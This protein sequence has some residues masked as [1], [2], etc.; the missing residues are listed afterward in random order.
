MVDYLKNL[1]LCPL[2]LLLSLTISA[3]CK[4][5]HFLTPSDSVNVM[6]RNTVIGSGVGLYL[7]GSIWLYQSWYRNYPRTSFHLF[8][9]WNEWNNMDKLGHIYSGYGQTKYA[10]RALRWTGMKKD[11]SLLLG[12]ATGLV[13]QTTIEFMDAYSEKWGFSLPDIAANVIGVGIYGVQEKLWNKQIFK[14]KFSSTPKTYDDHPLY[15]GDMSSSL[16]MRAEQLYGKS[17]RERLLKDY[18]GQSYW[19]TVDIHDLLPENNKWPKWLD[20]AIGYG[21]E[22]MFGGFSNSWHEGPYTFSAPPSYERYQEWYITFDLDI[23]DIPF[24]SRILKTF[25]TMFS[26]F[27]IPTPTIAFNSNG[28]IVFHIL[29]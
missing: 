1:F 26:I 15:D 18:N 16:K 20:L 10:H 3:Q 22:N 24:K 21:S 6:R 12:M 25:G 8:N 9:D 4:I 14:I 2:F 13:Y 7:T 11:K 23:E 29:R 17:F 28:E 5:D 19:L 27:K